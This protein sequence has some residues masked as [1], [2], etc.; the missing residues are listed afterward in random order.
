MEYVQ[1]RVHGDMLEGQQSSKDIFAGWLLMLIAL[2]GFLHYTVRWL[3]RIASCP[4]ARCATLP[5]ILLKFKIFMENTVISEP[6]VFVTW[7]LWTAV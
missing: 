7:F 2:V 6:T 4:S 1:R 3:T 5:Q